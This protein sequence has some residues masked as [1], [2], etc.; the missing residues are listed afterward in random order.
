[1]PSSR[2]NK[3]SSPKRKHSANSKR[4]G[5]AKKTVEVPDGEGWTRTVEVP[6][7]DGDPVGAEHL[8]PGHDHSHGT[9]RCAACKAEE[10]SQREGGIPWDQ[11]CR[12]LIEVLGGKT[13]WHDAHDHAWLQERGVNMDDAKNY[14]VRN[15]T[16]TAYAKLRKRFP[17]PK[18]KKQASKEALIPDVKVETKLATL[19]VA[20][21]IEYW[22]EA[23]RTGKLDNEKIRDVGDLVHAIHQE[24]EEWIEV[25]EDR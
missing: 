8:P 5:G 17:V 15:F 4:S 24:C 11:W 3:K 2:A 12:Q 20:T 23:V 18:L 9:S 14:W 19:E 1:M 16:P 21:R 10:A 22:L 6:D 7:D 25:L 13:C